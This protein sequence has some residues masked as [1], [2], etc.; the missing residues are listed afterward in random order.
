VLT[1]PSRLRVG[2]NQRS[3]RRASGAKIV[4]DVERGADVIEQVDPRQREPRR[5]LD[6]SDAIE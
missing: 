6:G 2:E 5:Q 1:A 3:G 4:R